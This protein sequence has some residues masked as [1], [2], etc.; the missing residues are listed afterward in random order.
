LNNA[1]VVC[2]RCSRPLDLDDYESREWVPK[3]E[4]MP[5]RG[6]KVRPFSTHRLGINYIIG[7]LLD[8][9]QNNFLR[10]FKNTVLG[11]A[12][13]GG[14]ARISQEEVDAA[15]TKGQSR[16][17][18]ISK[19]SDVFVGIDVG[20][21]CTVITGRGT[22]AED[23]DPIR[24][25]FVHIDDL[26][27]HVGMLKGL[28]NIASGAMDR[29]PY[30]PTAREVWKV[31][32]G[33][34]WPVEYR[35]S[36]EINPVFDVEK[37]LTHFQVDRTTVLDRVQARFKSRTISLN[38]WNQD[39]RQIIGEHFRNMVRK[40]EPEV[41]AV[42]EKLDPADHSFHAMAFMLTA[43]SLPTVIAL[44]NK[45]EVRSTIGIIGVD[46]ASSTARLPG[47]S[48]PQNNSLRIIRTSV[49]G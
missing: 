38:G 28:Y 3:H 4:N 14:Q 2:E 36:K 47:Y 9:K 40:E 16:V 10:G 49:Y 42:W 34:I 29:H 23:I 21:I 45:V 24:I 11:E 19:G 20:Q 12:D 26:I 15:F 27:K 5:N 37:N 25:E 46:D 43:P 35:G 1:E 48:A 44:Y 22:C 33:R 30:E 41:P 18:E 13:E 17:P 6:Y 39:H 7:Q 32:D 8:Y 31:S